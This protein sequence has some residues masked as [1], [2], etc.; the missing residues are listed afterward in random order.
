[1]AWRGIDAGRFG[2]TPRPR[3]GQRQLLADLG[4]TPATNPLKAPSRARRTF[5]QTVQLLE[6]F[7]AREGRP[8]TAREEILV[9]GDTVKISPWLAKATPS[10]APDSSRPTTPR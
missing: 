3:S 10:I 1:M 6:L 2:G 8:P 4:L 5:A 9:D 7:I